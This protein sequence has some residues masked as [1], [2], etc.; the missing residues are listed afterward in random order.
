MNTMSETLPLPTGWKPVSHPPSLFCRYEFESYVRTREFLDGLML[1]SEDTQLFPD[2]GFGKTYVNVTIH[3]K[4]D[5]MPGAAEIE[6][7]ERAA[8]LATAGIV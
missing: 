3:G 5:Q 2:L 7:A 4:N 6:F 8:C 1:L